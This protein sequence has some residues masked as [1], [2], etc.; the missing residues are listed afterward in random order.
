MKKL[1]YLVIGIGLLTQA[2]NKNTS[3]DTGKLSEANEMLSK[4]EMGTFEIPGADGL[5]VT[6]DYYPDDTAKAIIILCHQAGY[7]RGEYR[8]IAPKLLHKGYACIAVDQRSG[9]VS[10]GID[11]ETAKRAL[12]MGLPTKYM[13]ARADIEAVVD[14]VANNTEKKIYLWGSS[15]SASLALLI[16]KQDA[17]VK[18]VIAFSPGEYLDNQTTVRRESAGINK[19]VF[20]T[21]SILEYDLIVKQIV[22]VLPSEYITAHKPDGVSDHGSKTLN[23]QSNATDVTYVKLF[24]FLRK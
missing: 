15:Y 7:S 2:C 5:D 22:E 17:R 18:K 14:Y 12:E 9:K 21:G 8:D 23:M 13:D 1:F 3:T 10:Y 24:D 6:V 19:P 4:G 20:I 16:G 11:N